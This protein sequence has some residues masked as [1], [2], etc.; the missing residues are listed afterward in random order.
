[1][2]AAAMAQR[3]K[4]KPLGLCAFLVPHNDLTARAK[5]SG[6]VRLAYAEC[7]RLRPAR[8]RAH[9]PALVVLVP[10]FGVPQHVISGLRYNVSQRVLDEIQHLIGKR[11]DLQRWARRQSASNLPNGLRHVMYD[12]AL[13]NC[14]DRARQAKTQGG[15][16]SRPSAWPQQAR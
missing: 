5:A 9:E 2:H 14:T 10:P 15:E 4:P 8:L 11:V 3:R 12:R 1:M 13:R 6:F 7:Y 16:Q